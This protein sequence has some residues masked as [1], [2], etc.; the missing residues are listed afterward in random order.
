MKR[1][2]ASS[3][4]AVMAVGCLTACGGNGATEA[5]N[6]PNVKTI[7]VWAFTDEVLYDRGTSLTA[8]E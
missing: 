1:L 2:I 7:N 3:L 4:C 6:D 5:T 8:A